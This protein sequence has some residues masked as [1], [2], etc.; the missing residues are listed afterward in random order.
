MRFLFIPS[1]LFL[2]MLYACS[3]ALN[4]QKTEKSEYVLSD[5]SNAG[6]DSI[7]NAFIVPYREK[8]EGAMSEVIGESDYSMEKGVP[9]SRLGNFVADACM[10]ES[11]K[12]FYPADGKPADFAFLNNGGLRRSLPKGAITRGDIFELMPFENELVVLT[13]N[14][15]IVKKIFNFIASKDGG[16]VS[17]AS[18]RIQDHQATNILIQQLPLDSTRT[19][20]ALTSDYLANGGDSFDFLKDLKRESVSLKVRD[21]IIR[22]IVATTKSGK[23]ISINTDGRITNVQ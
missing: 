10:T 18:F 1:M 15:E 5:S 23:K 21:A 17:G 2:S 22:N 13:M 3:P 20:K 7:I 16:P 11:A 12:V 6:G 4:I 19:Y 9:E 14:A 8:V